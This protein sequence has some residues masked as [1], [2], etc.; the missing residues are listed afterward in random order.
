[1]KIQLKDLFITYIVYNNKAGKYF[2]NSS[3]LFRPF[4]LI[5]ER[6]KIRFNPITCSNDQTNKQSNNLLKFM[7]KK[8][9]KKCTKFIIFSTKRK[10]IVINRMEKS[11]NVTDKTN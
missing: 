8:I 2:A 5:I 1:M 11:S 4:L 10:R 9:K 6:L 7:Q 3:W